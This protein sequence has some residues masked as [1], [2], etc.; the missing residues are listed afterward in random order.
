MRAAG[1]RYRAWER[2]LTEHGQLLDVALLR[3][4]GAASLQDID[5]QAEITALEPP[6]DREAMTYY[7]LIQAKSYDEAV[8]IARG[9]PMLT[10][11]ARI[12]LREIED[13]GPPST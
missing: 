3:T 2:D 6:A 13:W 1:K 9:C 11:G 7:W 8:R 5:G 4:E 10:L 12:E